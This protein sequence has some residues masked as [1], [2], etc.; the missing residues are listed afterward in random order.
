[1]KVDREFSPKLAEFLATVD[2]EAL[3]SLRRQEAKKRFMLMVEEVQ[4]EAARNGL[5]PEL[6]E[7]IL[8]EPESASRS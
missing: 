3:D 7:T 5:T 2:D 8:N 1:M 6:L 4:A